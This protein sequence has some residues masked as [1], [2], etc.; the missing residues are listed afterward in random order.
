MDEELTPIEVMVLYQT[1]FN[2]I[3]DEVKP[4]G[5]G[6][7]SEMDKYFYD[8]YQ[9]TG[10]KSFDI[11]LRA[12]YVGTYVLRFSKPT[13]QE[14]YDELEVSNYVELT[15]LLDSTEN[16]YLLE[17]LR[18]F[19]T[20]RCI[21]EFARYYFDETGEVLDGCEVQH[22]VIPPKGREYQGGTFRIDHDKVRSIIESGALPGS[23][24]R[25]LLE[26]GSDD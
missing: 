23:V 14:E 5:H 26:G 10:A 18:E 1:V 6:M 15:E 13:A 16:R 19:V 24:T 7:R 17:Q 20:T 9:K 3:A 11:Y 21:R 4:S 25:Y 12:E 2:R 8:M 22:V